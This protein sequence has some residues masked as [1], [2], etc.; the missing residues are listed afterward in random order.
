M[1]RTLV[2]GNTQIMPESISNEEIMYPVDNGGQGIEI[3]KIEDGAHIVRTNAPVDGN[4]NMDGNRITGAGPAIDSNDVVIKSQLDSISAGLDPKESVRVATTGGNITL[5][6]QQTIDGISLSA[7]DRVLVKD[8]SNL[9]ENGIYIVSTGDWTRSEDADQNNGEVSGG[10]FTFVEAGTVNAGTGW[11]IVADGTL[12]PSDPSIGVQPTDSDIVFTQ[13]AGGGAMTGGFGIYV[14]GSDINADVDGSTIVN[15]GGTGDKLS[16]PTGGITAVQLATD[17]V[18]RN[19]ILDD[20]VTAAKLNVDVAGSG[21]IQA[22]SGALQ[23]DVDSSTIIING[24]TLEV[25]ASALTPDLVGNGLINNA[26]N[27]DVNVDGS[28]IQIVGGQLQVNSTGIV[29]AMDGN[30]LSA[31]GAELDVNVDNVTIEIDTDVLKVKDAGITETQIASSALGSGLTGGSGTKLTVD[32]S[33]V[34]TADNYVVREVLPI[35]PATYNDGDTTFQLGASQVPGTEMVFVNGILM[36]EGAGNDYTIN[37][38]G[39]II[40]TF[41]LR[42]DGTKVDKIAVTYFKA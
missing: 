33:V 41:G 14:S 32:T 26:G 15:T 25:D 39:Q 10:M 38:T 8:Q 27:L 18:T 19:K 22:V 37:S 11:V 3:A 6:A 35:A 12:T 31:N 28:S 9:K 34:L 17:S 2:R 40:F 21:I 4:I 24:N 13:F 1:A 23:V 7:G 20:E 5:N 30:G 36:E 42:N 29:G 16:V